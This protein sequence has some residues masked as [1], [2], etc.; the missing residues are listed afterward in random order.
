M[1]MRKHIILDKVYRRRGL[2]STPSCSYSQPSFGIK[3]L[4]MLLLLLLLMYTK[5]LDF[6]EKKSDLCRNFHPCSISTTNATY[7]S[8][9]SLSLRTNEQLVSFLQPG[10]RNFKGG[11]EKKRWMDVEAKDA[12]FL[13]TDR[14]K[15]RSSRHV[16]AQRS[17]QQ[18]NCVNTK[19]RQK[20]IDN[21]KKD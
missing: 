5:T 11:N 3:A 21:Q 1:G 16:P 6:P 4:A 19:K 14:L 15:F 17:I 20:L 2:V 7:H 13:I 9:F 12:K 10:W 8:C 18:L